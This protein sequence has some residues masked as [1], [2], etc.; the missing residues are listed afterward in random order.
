MAGIRAE[1]VNRRREVRAYGLAESS[2]YVRERATAVPG[3]RRRRLPC[4]P[5][6]R[7]AVVDRGPDHDARVAAGARGAADSRRRAASPRRAHSRNSRH[8]STE[9]R[10]RAC[11][12]ER[13]A[14]RGSRPGFASFAVS[15]APSSISRRDHD[16]RRAAVARL[17]LL[18]ASRLRRP[19]RGRR[20]RRSRA[21]RGER[22]AARGRAGPALCANVAFAICGRG[23]FAESA[24]LRRPRRGRRARS[25]DSS[26]RRRVA[27]ARVPSE[28]R[29]A[30]ESPPA[31]AFCAPA[32]RRR[33]SRARAATRGP[34]RASACARAQFE[35]LVAG[36]R[37]G[38]HA[39][40]GSRRRAWARPD[41]ALSA[42][43]APSSIACRNTTRGSPPA[44]KAPPI[45]AGEPRRGRR[46]PSGRGAARGSRPNRAFCAPARRRR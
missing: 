22:G 44:R 18:L 46:A 17:V 38:A 42:R 6:H 45:P 23:C 31:P 2:G 37:V 4:S 12:R 28:S 16:A 32:R 8:S 20:V 19:R 11:R 14:A 7:V 30:R 29:S 41:R 36:E 10:G 33:R 39:P 27:R 40:S 35:P 9:P 43:A 1:E 5:R 26:R 34:T 21:C 13:G 3:Y 25:R 15:V 24:R